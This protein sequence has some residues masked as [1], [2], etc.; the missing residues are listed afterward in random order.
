MLKFPPGMGT[1]MFCIA[2]QH[3]NQYFKS[4]DDMMGGNSKELF[5]LDYLYSNTSIAIE[6]GLAIQSY[7]CEEK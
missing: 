4:M 5:T 7:H 3:N 1:L 6:K 2:R